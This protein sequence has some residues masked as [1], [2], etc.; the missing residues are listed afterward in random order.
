ML[1]VSHLLFPL[2]RPGTLLAWAACHLAQPPESSAAITTISTSSC[3]QP[4]Q[5]QRA[6]SPPPPPRF[7]PPSLQC[8]CHERSRLAAA[9]WAVWQ[10][11]RLNAYVHRSVHS[12][13]ATCQSSKKAGA[14]AKTRNI[15]DIQPVLC[16]GYCV[17]AK[18]ARA[19]N[20]HARQLCC[21]VSLIVWQHGVCFGLLQQHEGL[22][23]EICVALDN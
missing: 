7:A 23:G 11:A 3:S 9:A 22:S 21:C 20:K 16:V 10:N 13:C 17:E 18:E 4:T 12:W 8:P 14:Q 6:T 19:G 15:V 5:W 1:L 2:Q